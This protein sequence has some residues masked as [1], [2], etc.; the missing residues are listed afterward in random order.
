MLRSVSINA[1]ISVAVLIKYVW[2]MAMSFRL[3]K[4]FGIAPL[5]NDSTTVGISIWIYGINIQCLIHDS[6]I[7]NGKFPKVKFNEHGKGL[8]CLVGLKMI[9]NKSIMF[10]Q[11]VGLGRANATRPIL[12]HSANP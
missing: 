4:L 8:S 12:K 3:P 7:S 10:A 11:Q 5:T 2:I 9:L 1:V 6:P